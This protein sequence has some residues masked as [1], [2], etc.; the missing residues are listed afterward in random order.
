MH[1]ADYIRCLK[2]EFKRNEDRTCG[3]VYGFLC[4]RVALSG[5]RKGEAFEI[6][7]NYEIQTDRQTDRQ[8]LL[9]VNK[10]F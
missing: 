1:F 8:T 2:K 10:A 7:A 4:V 5:D 6:L 9:S 3:H